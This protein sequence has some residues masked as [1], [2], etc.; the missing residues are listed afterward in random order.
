MAE[1]TRYKI[2]IWFLFRQQRNNSK[3]C[4]QYECISCY[5]YWCGGYTKNKCPLCGKLVN[6]LPPEKIIATGWFN[7]K[8]ERIY[9]GASRGDITSKCYG[10]NAENL[11]AFIQP[12]LYNL[13][14]TGNTNYCSACRGYKNCPIVN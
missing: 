8:C 5:I 12:P 6:K 7:C 1:D 3:H 11:P 4:F 10:C 2:N 13:R 14:K 9:A